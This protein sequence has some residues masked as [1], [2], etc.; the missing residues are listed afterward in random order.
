V[1]NEHVQGW[2]YQLSVFTN[3]VLDE[4]HAG[5]ANVVDQWFAAW[6]EPDSARR[7]DAFARMASPQIR[8]RDRFS[9]IEGLDDL[10]AHTGAAQRFMPGIRM[11]RR[12]DIRHC[13]GTVLADWIW[14]T[15]AGEERARGTNMFSFRPDGRIESVTGFM[16][17]AS[18]RSTR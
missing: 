7:H 8:F 12:G 10:V 5:A 4:V 17:M 15:A 14:L 11:E 2:R 1:R 3:V 16:A 13:Q 6:A 18:D 9:V